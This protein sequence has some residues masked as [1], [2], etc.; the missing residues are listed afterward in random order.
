MCCSPGEHP[1]VIRVLSYIV[2]GVHGVLATYGVLGLRGLLD[3]D[4]LLG[5]QGLL[6]LVLFTWVIRP[7]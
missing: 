5:L 2:L 6:D 3:S 1:G 4:G 7:P